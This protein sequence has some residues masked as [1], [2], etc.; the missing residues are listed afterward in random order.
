MARVDT[1]QLIEDLVKSGLSKKPAE[2]LGRAFLDNSNEEFISK[3]Q[4]NHLEKE[5]TDIKTDLAVIKQTMSTKSDLAEVKTE[6]KTEIA[7]LRA[8][9]R[10]GMALLLAIAGMLAKLTFFNT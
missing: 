10:W 9:I 1:H 5:Q 7:G 4:I 3:E 2:I 8:D 6:L